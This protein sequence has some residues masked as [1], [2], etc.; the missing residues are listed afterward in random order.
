MAL[1]SLAVL[2]FPAETRT[3]SVP[4]DKM[5]KTTLFLNKAVF[6]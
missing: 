3:P 2:A 5:R 6:N 1:L 4:N